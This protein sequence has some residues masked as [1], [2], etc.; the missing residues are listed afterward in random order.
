MRGYFLS[1][2]R[3]NDFVKGNKRKTY[4]K[5]NFIKTKNFLIEILLK[6]WIGNSQRV[7]MT[8]DLLKN[9]CKSIANNNNPIKC[10]QRL[11]WTFHRGRSEWPISL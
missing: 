10:A 8:K 7:E 3:Q 11:K 4:Y 6:S 5:L 2:N 1:Q 9:T